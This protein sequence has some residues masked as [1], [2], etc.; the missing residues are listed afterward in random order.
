MNLS[1][2]SKGALEVLRHHKTEKHLRRD[3]R[4][5]YEH[6]KTINPVSG[7]VEYEVKYEVRDKY[8]RIRDPYQF[9]DAPLVELGPKFPFN[10]EIANKDAEPVVDVE[11]D[12]HS[13]LTLIATF[14][15]RFGDFSSLQHLSTRIGLSAERQDQLTTI[16]RS[17]Q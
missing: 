3:Q 14:L 1:C 9:I 12:T 7:K 2:K 11:H 10:D 15:V 5:R 17:R 13:Q 4:W 16:D 8:G 6:L